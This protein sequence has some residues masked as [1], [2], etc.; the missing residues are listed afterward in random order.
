[1]NPFEQ[2]AAPADTLFRSW[3]E[4]YPAPYDKNETDPYTK[5]RIILMNGTEFEAVWFTHQFHRHC[6]NDD[7]RRELA[8]LRRTEQQQQKRIACLKPIDEPILE[9]TIAY[10]QL[11]VDLTAILA[12]RDPDPYVVSV[13]DLALLED[14]DHL[15]RYADLLDFEGGVHAERLVGSYTEIMPGRP[16]ISEHRHPRDSVRR[17][18]DFAKAAPITKL[19]TAI[20]TAAEQ[21][22]MNFYMNQCG[23]YTSDLGRRLYQEIA[24]IE[25]QHV[26]QY[27]ALLDTSCTWLENLLMHEYTECYLYWSCFEDETDAKVKKIWEQHFEQEL[28]HLHAA[29]HL[30]EKYENK[31]WQQVIPAGEFP[32][33][34]KFAPQKEYVRKVLAETVENTAQCTDP[35]V[36][37]SELPAD[38]DF[39]AYQAAVCPDTAQVASHQVIRTAI[40]ECG[41]DYRFE[42]SEHPVPAL[43]D[44]TKDN[45]SVGRKA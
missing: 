30:L 3:K 28:S 15:Y 18:C 38:A 42:E 5:T 32:P 36:P 26:T 22:T 44:R 21:Q 4:L 14:F 31:H 7:L 6:Q 35:A 9:T 13:M 11:A 12:Q 43:R 19:D 40:Q 8:V 39:F 29:A 37:V 17:A 25:E 10:E 1:M 34:L 45:T 16:T 24:M 2:K 23:F 20:I 33:L 27:G 41:E